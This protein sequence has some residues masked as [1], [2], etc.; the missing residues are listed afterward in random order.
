[1]DYLRR[2]IFVNPDYG[3]L[4]FLLTLTKESSGLSITS[5]RL[6]SSRKLELVTA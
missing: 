4:W 6:R 3:R 2:W 5:L 1:M